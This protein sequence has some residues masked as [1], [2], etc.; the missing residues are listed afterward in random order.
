M[1]SE[2]DRVHGT[3]LAVVVLA[4]A[5]SLFATAVAAGDKSGAI[6]RPFRVPSGS[7]QSATADRSL[8]ASNRFFDP[9]L[10]TNGQT[11]ATPRAPCRAATV[12][13]T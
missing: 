10:G 13:A 4:L 6:F 1:K 12:P 7:V 2:R 11:C 9:D 3:G 5:T 8:D